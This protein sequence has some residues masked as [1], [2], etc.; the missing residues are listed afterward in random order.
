MKVKEGPENYLFFL[1]P[2]CDEP[3][4]IRHGNGTW[5]WNGD[6]EKPTFSPSVRVYNNERTLCH[7]F[8][9]DGK[10]AFCGDSPHALANQTVEL[11]DWDAKWD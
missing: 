5:A 1:C 2:G 8:V 9:T 3:H 10:I 6:K 4:A 11:P 7:S